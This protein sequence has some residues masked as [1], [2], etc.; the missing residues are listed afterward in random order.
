MHRFIATLAAVALS[1]AAFAQTNSSQQVQLLAPQLVPF[2]GSSGNFDSLV[3]G[4]T[5]G[6]PVT[7]ATVGTDGSL[8][9][10][11]FIPGTTLSAPDAARL[12]ESARQS[13]IARGIAT[14][15]GQ[16]LA[17]ALMG[18][19]IT[20][21]S[22]STLITGALT[23]STTPPSA[24]QVRTDSAALQG[25]AG[26]PNLSPAQLQA[27]RNALATGSGVTL[28]TGTGTGTTQN[29]SFTPTGGRMSDF[30]VN[31]TL[32]LAATLLA[33]QGILNPTAE[34]LRVA[35][36]GGALVAANGIS[37]T[38]QGVLQGQVQ[39]TSNS[40]DLSTSASPVSGTSDT[41]APVS[42]TPGS[43]SAIGGT[44]STG[45]GVAARTGRR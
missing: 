30:Q 42:R 7:L 12:L 3:T 27:V 19:T 9:I 41:A 37:V 34:Q 22:G 25:G 40:R 20:T 5:T 28:T 16:Q 10:V 36:F 4:L 23:G 45:S 8:Q 2:S 35:L 44:S 24:V 38:V 17:A 14:P 1:A 43:A 33:Q 39:S 31:Q 29:V 13:L 21:P 32:Q 26:A 6:V 18:G 15:S 11:T